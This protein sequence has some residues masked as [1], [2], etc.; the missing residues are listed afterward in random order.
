MTAPLPF[1]DMPGKALGYQLR[2]GA[3]GAPYDEMLRPDGALRP[4]WREVCTFLERLGP[5]EIGRRWTQAR[6]ILHDNGAA[7]HYYSG[8]A[9]ALRAWELNPVPLR[10]PKDEWLTI[11]KAVRQRG[12]LLN[13]LLND[14]YG[15]RELLKSGLIP[16]AI[17]LG[18]SSYLRPCVGAPVP[19]DARLAF[20]A[21]D[22][23]RAPDGKWWVVSDRT[24]SPSGIGYA[25]ENR[26][27]VSRVYPEIFRTARI[28][29]LGW[30]FAKLKEAFAALSPRAGVEP[31]I[32]L[33]TPGRFNEVYFEHAYL[34]RQLGFPLVEGQDLTVRD[35]R[36][37]IKTLQG[38]QQVDVI[39]R[40]VDE[41][42]C[43][44][45]EL[46]DD[47]LLGVPGLLDAV[48]AGTVAVANALG[49]G[50]LQCPALGA[51]LPALCKE[52]C[53]EELLLPSL[54]TWWCGDK[55]AREYV[56]KNLHGLVVKDAFYYP[57]EHVAERSQGKLAA[58][59]ESR[60]E[61]Y[62]AQEY[63]RL[64]QSPDFCD[65]RLEP[66]SVILRVFAVRCGD[67]YE[68]MP[69]GLTRVAEDE[70]SYDILLQQAGGSKDTWVDIEDREEGEE[71]A[72]VRK[73]AFHVRSSLTSRTADN[74]FWLGRYAA[75]SEFT[76]RMVRGAL[77]NLSDED[78]RAD[79]ADYV[80]LLETL[81]YFGQFH[82]TVDMGDA[83]EKLGVIIV[84]QMHDLNNPNS[85]KS[86]IQRLR[87]IATTVRDQVTNDTWR[88]VNQLSGVLGGDGDISVNEAALR[89][90]QVI[91]HLSACNGVL[92]ENMA[93][94]FGWRFVDLGRRIERSIYSARLVA[95]SL[96]AAAP[97]PG[98][99][100][101]LL[102]VFD[103][104]IT[105]R[106]RYAALR[107]ETAMEMLLCDESNPRSLASQLVSVLDDLVHLPREGTGA[108]YKLPEERLV[109]RQLSDVRLLEF[110]G[111]S[112]ES[113]PLR[114]ALAGVERSMEKLSEFVT[115]R[116]FTHLRTSSVGRDMV[117]DALPEA[118]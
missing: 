109:L 98:R 53:G 112:M 80:P 65:G 88:V 13:H 7:Y 103:A 21:V 91:L 106:Q 3:H 42:Y 39:V 55:A 72:G 25:L 22:L 52:I 63:V 38:L 101:V 67:D 116:F 9:N 40:R 104:V 44:P 26:V 46:R 100:Q 110:N 107:P 74:L 19:K 47:S 83:L 5:E 113:A 32:V 56:L 8:S 28:A 27:V 68:V 105:Y 84:R 89:L 60:P 30:F 45:L 20:Y 49:S 78:G 92:G 95:E 35:G 31:E 16:P 41:E 36:V 96:A 114:E 102:D 117:S 79:F 51:F 50:V 17:V 11:E 6:R 94:D 75:R 81:R 43:D 61:F 29:R 93:R 90:N 69:G 1:T 73:E 97:G 77:E 58:A 99:F 85:L 76:A 14:L 118:V 82:P 37:Y 23:A 48:R 108:G 87:E 71:P 86:T 62:A 2:L 18:N 15:P 10:V 12:R 70:S 111:A 33:L 57:G 59:M 66:R 64:S 34:S 54:A 115:V 4:H 24:Q